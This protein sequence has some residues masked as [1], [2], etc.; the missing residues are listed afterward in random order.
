MC[1]EL[2][3]AVRDHKDEQGRQLSEVFLRVPK[4]RYCGIKAN[5]NSAING[6]C[7]ILRFGRLTHLWVLLGS[8]FKHKEVT[9]MSDLSRAFSGIS[10]I[11]MKWCPSQLI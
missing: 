8:T 9:V 5:A 11:T 2:F 10:Q 7:I 1:H 6:A 3:N 4:R